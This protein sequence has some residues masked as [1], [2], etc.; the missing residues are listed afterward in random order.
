MVP[1]YRIVWTDENGGTGHG[2]YCLPRNTAILWLSY[3]RTKYP[4]M[5]HL[6]ERQPLSPSSLNASA[7]GQGV[8]QRPL[9]EQRPLVG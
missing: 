4:S 9:V 3:L 5:I 7:S 1:L 2:E 8:G 6:L